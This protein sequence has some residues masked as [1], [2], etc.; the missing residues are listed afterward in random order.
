[1]LLRPIAHCSSVSGWFI[2]QKYCR[3]WVLCF[4][5]LLSNKQYN[6]PVT[7]RHGSSSLVL[8]GFVLL[9]L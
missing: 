9:Y 6:I 8:A 7:S 3:I 4:R 2:Y 1:L 5:H